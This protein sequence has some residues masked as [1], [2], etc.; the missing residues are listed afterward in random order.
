M[1]IRKNLFLY[2]EYSMLATVYTTHD[3]NIYQIQDN[4]IKLKESIKQSCLTRKSLQKRMIVE[5]LRAGYLLQQIKSEIPHGDWVNW[6]KENS[7][8]LGYN[9]IASHPLRAMQSDMTLY[10]TWQPYLEEFEKL[11]I[12]PSKDYVTNIESFIDTLNVAEIET[13]VSALQKF[14]AKDTPEL[15]MDLAIDRL[16]NGAVLKIADANNIINIAKA[17][18]ELPENKRDTATRLAKKGANTT[19]IKRSGDL[20]DT[21]LTEIETNGSLYVPALDKHVPISDIGES[22]IELTIGRSDIEHEL[23]RQKA[24]SESLANGRQTR[25]EFDFVASLEGSSAQI[26]H[27]IH[28]II[29]GD[30]V[31]R[32]TVYKNK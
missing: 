7:E 21:L 17:I 32:I 1:Y 28:D 16:T 25:L 19:L 12:I 14:S 8:A 18:D 27:Q 2:G 30:H 13:T 29:N 20:N 31:F 11:K 15:A 10:R 4:I 6:T 22:D 26:L 5:S 9:Q 24:I 3:T 23:Q